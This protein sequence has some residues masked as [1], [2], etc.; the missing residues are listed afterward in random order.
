MASDL[1]MWLYNR[2]VVSLIGSVLPVRWFGPEPPPEA[3]LTKAGEPMKIEIVAH[4][5]QYAHMLAYQLQSV[6]EHTPDS[7]QLTYTLYYSPEDRATA[8]L[9]AHYNTLKSDHLHWN[10]QPIEAT[11]LK[12][13]AIGRNRSALATTANWIWFADCDL[14]FHR[15]CIASLDN[16]L[17]KRALR[18]AYPASECITAL[19]PPEDAML[20]VDP[21]VTPQPIIDP[22]RFSGSPIHKAK[23]AFQIV[24]GDVARQCGYCPHLG[25]YQ[26]PTSHWRKTFED[27]AF[28]KLIKDQGTPV[29]IVGLHRIRHQEKGRYRG[30]SAVARILSRVRTTIRATRG[31]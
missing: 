18:L 4:C 15:N 13:R 26:R 8:A 3:E 28:R 20:H 19:L 27:T 14:I 16:T 17:R 2:C 11:E 29:D 21:G 5:W 23:G 30:G 9:I 7:V 25:P 31:N 10:W 12:R 1:S 24:H 22:Q 6:W